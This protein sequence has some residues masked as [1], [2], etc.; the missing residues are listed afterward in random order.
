MWCHILCFSKTFQ[1][2]IIKCMVPA[3]CPCQSKAAPRCENCNCGKEGRQ[4]TICAPGRFDC[5]YNRGTTLNFVQS[6]SQP[7][8]DDRSEKTDVDLRT[9]PC[10]GLCISGGNA[11]LAHHSHQTELKLSVIAVDVRAIQSAVEVGKIRTRRYR[12]FVFAR[13]LT[14]T[15]EV[16]IV[17]A[18]SVATP[19]SRAEQSTQYTAFACGLTS[20]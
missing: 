18:R 3:H 14:T 16:R 9:K 7:I 2:K 6:T 12:R 8:P 15:A 5:F 1:T 19:I 11:S 17:V 13:E 4:C 20:L 10:T